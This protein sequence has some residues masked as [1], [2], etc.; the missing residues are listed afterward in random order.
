[1]SQQS[2]KAFR[3][4]MVLRLASL[5]DEARRKGRLRTLPELAERH[6][7]SERTIRRDVEALRTL[8]IFIGWG[9][10]D[11]REPKEDGEA[12]RGNERYAYEREQQADIQR[13]LK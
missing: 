1:M 11:D 9:P 10:D 5:I 6:K 12:F 4:R 8:G 7:C 2:A 3:C 13:V